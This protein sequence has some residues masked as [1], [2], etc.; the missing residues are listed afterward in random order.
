[1]P[2]L[3]VPLNYRGIEMPVL[4]V[5]VRE[6]AECDNLLINT[7]ASG[8]HTITNNANV[9]GIENDSTP[10]NNKRL[11]NVNGII[12]IIPSLSLYS[13]TFMIMGI[14]FI[15]FRRPWKQTLSHIP[16]VISIF[17]SSFSVIENFFINNWLDSQ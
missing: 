12:R 3:W 2:V 16:P 14:F 1:M 11:V 8:F 4:W 17:V 10:A 15:V 13:L 5:I 6:T 9:T 7:N